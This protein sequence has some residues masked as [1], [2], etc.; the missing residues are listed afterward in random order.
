MIQNR[1]KYI[2]L[3]TV[4]FVLAF[5]RLVPHPPNVTPIAAMALFAGTFFAN[6]IWAYLVPILA[7]VISDLILGFHSTVVYVY[8]GIL[9]TVFIGSK[10]KKI[11]ILSVSACAFAASIVFFMVT[12]FGAWLHHEM[13]TQN[14]T[15]LLQAYVAGLPFL[16]NALIA[17]LI[18]SYLVFFGLNGFFDIK[19]TVKST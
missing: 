14:F 11:S 4:I 7:M 18:F 2:F 9:I 1:F 3:V 15:G 6:R 19:S 17:N 10:L 16:R 12:N 5:M 13:Y 8:A